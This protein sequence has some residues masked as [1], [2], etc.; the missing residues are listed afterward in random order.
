MTA[1]LS[2]LL[3]IPLVLKRQRRVSD[4]L[5]AG[6]ILT[7]GIAALL[8][9]L[10]FAPTLLMWLAGALAP[11]RL[12]PLVVLYAL[13]GVLLYWY[14]FAMGGRDI[15]VTRGVKI[16]FTVLFVLPFVQ[17]IFSDDIGDP[18]FYLQAMTVVTGP[19]LI[20][21]IYYGFRALRVLRQ[22][23]QFIRER[24]SNIDDI[25]L[26]WLKYSA[27]GFI[28]IWC[29]RL[30]GYFMPAFGGMKLANVFGEGANYPAVLLIS[31]MVILGLSHGQY[32]A[33]TSDDE[34]DSGDAKAKT[35]TPNPAMVEKLEDLMTRVKVYQDPDLNLDGLADSMDTSPRSLSALI[36]GHYNQNFYDFVNNYRVLDAKQRLQSPDE[37]EKTVQN[38]FEDAGFN[39]KSTFNT[40]FKRVTGN[41]PTEFRRQF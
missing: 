11:F 18:N 37:R 13:Q 20:V 3:A 16:M 6:F 15:R 36:N 27:F 17:L 4:L 12:I 29:F 2:L 10:L 32:Q 24:H 8:Y 9:L 31:W 23:N 40:F 39:S 22:H 26:L 1:G 14:A 35:K 19:S 28:G 5:L 33:V 30:M 38:I 7:Q 25:N 21:S 41:T 34:P